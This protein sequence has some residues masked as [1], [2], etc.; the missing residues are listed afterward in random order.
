MKKKM[1]SAM[2]NSICNN[3]WEIKSLDTECLSDI[4]SLNSTRSSINMGGLSDEQISL[5]SARSS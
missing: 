4:E 2:D 1:E 3:S 5:L